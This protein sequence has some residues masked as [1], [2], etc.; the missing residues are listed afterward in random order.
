MP[1]CNQC[2]KEAHGEKF[3]TKCG[4]RIPVPAVSPGS[5]PGSAPGGMSIKRAARPNIPYKLIA[6]IA[7]AV[8]VI[9][10]VII[11][12][13]GRSY[14]KV[15]DIYIDSSFDGNI[16]KIMKLIPDDMIDKIVEEEYDGDREEMI[17][18]G[19]D[20][21]KVYTDIIDEYGKI[22]YDYEIEDEDN[23]SKSEIEDLCENYGLDSDKVKEAK[24]LEVKVNFKV[25]DEER[26]KTF[27]FTVGKMGRSWYLLDL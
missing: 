13:T 15:V 25:E 6:A 5:A 4:A 2:G 11:L 9:A 19:E 27:Y 16:K 14:K 24:E 10:V 23:L 18:D 7:G 21:L 12:L 8:I 1:F 22:S 17:A 26:D 3:C 20:A